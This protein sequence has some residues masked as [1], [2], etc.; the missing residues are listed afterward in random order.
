MSNFTIN[1]GGSR[2]SWMGWRQSQRECA[3]LLFGKNFAENCKLLENERIWTER[4]RGHIF[5]SPS[6]S[7]A[8]IKMTKLPFKCN[9]I[10]HF[11]Q[12]WDGKI[13]H[14]ISNV[15]MNMSQDPHPPLFLCN[16]AL[17]CN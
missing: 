12:I 6:L 16:E 4:G 9:A 13:L 2:I 11:S 8:L 15:K 7:S 14:T 5:S 1:C 3:N 10:L 17:P